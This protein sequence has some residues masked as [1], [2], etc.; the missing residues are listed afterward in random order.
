MATRRKVREE[1]YISFEARRLYEGYPLPF[2]IFYKDGNAIKLLFQRGKLFGRAEKSMLIKDDIAALYVR[3]LEK[4]NLEHYILKR[5]YSLKLKTSFLENSLDFQF[6]YI[7]KEKH[8][9]IDRN[10][11]VPGMEV[12]FS[13]YT[14]RK[15]D[16][17]TILEAAENAARVI[18]D[19]ILNVEGDIVIKKSDIPLYLAYLRSVKRG[20]SRNK[21]IAVRESAKATIQELLD[22]PYDSEKIKQ[23]IFLVNS[24]IDKMLKDRDAIYTLLLLHTDDFYTYSHSVNTAVLSIGLGIAI[25]M[26]RKELEELGIGAILHDIG[27]SLLSP[28]I[29]NKQGKLSFTQYAIFQAHVIEGEKILSAHPE[30]PQESLVA[31]LQHHEKINGRGYPFKLSGDDIKLYGR[32][33]AIADC[34]DAMVTPR[35]FRAPQKPFEALSDIAKETGNYDPELLKAFIQ[36]LTKIK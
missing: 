33:T 14:F 25:G 6:F 21:L 27:K 12:D 10:I 5:P 20:G 11:L 16:I 15:P 2:D 13:L 30:I 35:P 7:K 9:Q 19:S 3:S 24:I 17:I 1:T 29:I 32:I 18:D 23:T 31:V 36:M 34:Y 22:N 28:E 4:T 26:S 8:F